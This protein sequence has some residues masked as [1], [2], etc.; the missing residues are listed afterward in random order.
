ML[1]SKIHRA[2]VSQANLHYVGSVTIDQALMRLADILPGEKVDIANI[3]NGAR[4]STYV[5]PGPEDS[6]IIGINGASVRLVSPGDLVIILSYIALPTEQARDHQPLIVHVYENNKVVLRD[7]DPA[8][9]V[10]GTDM[11][12]GDVVAR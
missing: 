1:K 5:N 6:G 4:F 3:N 12:R 8:G 7:H 11:V 2:T 9:A 10:P